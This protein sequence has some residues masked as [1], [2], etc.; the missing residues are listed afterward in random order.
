MNRNYAFANAL[1]A[2][3]ADLGLAHAAVSPGSRNT[4]LAIAAAETDGIEVTTHLDERSAA[5]FALGLARATDQ[6]VA[7]ICT[8]GTA[9]AQYLPALV[10]AS[11]AQIP[12]VV[13]T[14]DRP[15]ELRDLGAPQTIHQPDLYGRAAK[16]S[17][18]AAPPDPSADPAN[19][20]VRLA[21]QAW[22]TSQETPAGPVH[23]NLPMRDPLAPIPVDEPSNPARSTPVVHVGAPVAT[24][25]SLLSVARQLSGSK[26]LIVAGPSADSTHASAI[27]ELA[28]ALDCPVV[29]DILSGLRTGTHPMDHVVGTGDAIART[30]QL[31][32]GLRPDVIVRFGSIPTSKALWTWLSES[33][34]PQVW[35][36]AGNWREGIASASV[37]VRADA[38]DTARRLAD[39]VEPSDPTW[40]AAWVDA[41]D[42]VLT[43]WADRLEFPSE[44]AV[45]AALAQGLPDGA[46]LMVS[47]SMPIRDTDTFFGVQDRPLKIY[48][49]RAANGIDGI[50]ST[51]L[52]VAATG[53]PTFALVGDVAFLHDVSALGSARRLGL[54]LTVVV[55]DNDGGGIFHFLPQADHPE[56][57]ETLLATPHGSDLG[58]MAEGFGATVVRATDAPTF[59]QA[60]AKP[61]G[62]MVVLV[63]TDRSENERLHKALLDPA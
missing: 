40:R 35:I 32:A 55:I 30:G 13:L 53:R 54:D 44:P 31:D 47:S 23:L 56:H 43:S 19:Y 3:L 49:N 1:L 46:A 33:E 20:A 12:L 42:A 24:D 26:T 59:M 28:D 7:L 58:A 6:P 60:I 18:D 17:H 2:S 10:E 21:T 16:W 62:V 48:G 5:F 15:P 61:D 52:G 25:G 22:S 45:V 63:E 29:A 57:F 36:D 37:A 14:A 39:L 50:I 11:L 51:A 34:V 4:P 38:A 8:S 9:A 41:E 27:A